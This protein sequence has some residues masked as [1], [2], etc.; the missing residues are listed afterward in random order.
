MVTKRLTRHY[1]YL[2]STLLILKQQAG[3]CVKAL[4]HHKSTTQWLAGYALGGG[5]MWHADLMITHAC[6]H[7]INAIKIQ[8]EHARLHQQMHGNAS[9]GMGIHAPTSMGM[10]PQACMGMCT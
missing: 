10:H 1:F 8:S 7:L 5:N 9:T 4:G 6:S 2:L 3:S